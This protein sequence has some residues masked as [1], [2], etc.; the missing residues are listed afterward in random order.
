MIDP[1]FIF[2]RCNAG[3]LVCLGESA[4]LVVLPLI[5]GGVS[6][7]NAVMLSSD[8][9]V[10]VSQNT[11]ES[12]P[13]TRMSVGDA[14]LVCGLYRFRPRTKPVVKKMANIHTQT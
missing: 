5:A 14:G 10:T 3:M 11:E 12:P 2:F 6:R 13:T 1:V 4:Y 8:V 9:M 7:R